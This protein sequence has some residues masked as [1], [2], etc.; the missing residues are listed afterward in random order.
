MASKAALAF[1]RSKRTPAD[2]KK[3]WN[4]DP[5]GAAKWLENVAKATDGKIEGLAQVKKILAGRGTDEFKAEKLKALV[6]K[7][8]QIFEVLGAMGEA[9]A[10]RAPTLGWSAT[11]QGYAEAPAFTGTL[12]LEKGIVK[13]QTSRGTFDLD[14]S[15][16][17]WRD[18]VETAFLNQVVTIKGYPSADGKTLFIDQ[19]APG[20]E[21][22]FISGR[23]DIEGDK[24]YVAP[25]N[26][27]SGAKIEITHPELKKLLK[28]GGG[29]VDYSPAGVIL[30]G[31]VEVKKNG[32][33]VYPHNPEDGFYLLGRITKLNVRKL[34][35]KRVLHELQTGYF[36]VTDA[37]A[38]AGL[39]VPAKSKPG[40]R[41]GPAGDTTDGDTGPDVGRRTF[42]YVKIL[43]PDANANAGQLNGVRRLEVTWVGDASDQ[44]RHAFSGAT[45]AQNL[46]QVAKAVPAATPAKMTAEDA[47]FIPE[48]AAKFGK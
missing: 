7:R 11:P 43:G 37:I 46:A 26:T 20:A 29:L 19:F 34:P 15:R 39:K 3:F 36:R 44:G 24:V 2:L 22:D 5:L 35:G 32:E 21:A 12:K 28:G 8:P 42:F 45:T 4:A 10:A 25:A 38:P 18:E 33:A 41:V 6:E 17:N 40:A 31:K 48:D 30:P 23:I 47:T 13:L 14:L 16:T 9:Q 1:D 27:W